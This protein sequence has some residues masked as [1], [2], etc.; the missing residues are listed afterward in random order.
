VGAGPVLGG[1]AGRIRDTDAAATV[2]AP[3]FPGSSCIQKIEQKSKHLIIAV[4]FNE[5]HTNI[6]NIFN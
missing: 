5:F 2:G 6:R 3:E 4:T 1:L